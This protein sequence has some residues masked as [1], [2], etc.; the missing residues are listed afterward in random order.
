MTEYILRPSGPLAAVMRASAAGRI[1]LRRHGRPRKPPVRHRPQLLSLLLIAY[2]I[3]GCA[4][5][6]VHRLS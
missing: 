5:T 1:P 4:T 6:L 3:L 2:L